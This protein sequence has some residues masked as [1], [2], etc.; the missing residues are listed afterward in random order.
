[1]PDEFNSF[2]S[3]ECDDSDSSVDSADLQTQENIA[4]MRLMYRD[5]L[6]YDSIRSVCGASNKM[7]KKAFGST[8]TVLIRK[9][10]M[11]QSIL[12]SLKNDLYT[13]CK[14][15]IC[16]FVFDLGYRCDN[17]DYCW[18]PMSEKMKPWRELFGL[19]NIFEKYELGC[20]CKKLTPQGL[21]DHLRNHS[22]QMEKPCFFILLHPNLFR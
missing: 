7:M 3:Y 18:C 5:G 9:T 16:L 11:G 20:N 22:I 15:L 4:D 14:A 17:N 21:S 10:R 1:M 13:F 6:D 2:M 12:S 19:V 8:S